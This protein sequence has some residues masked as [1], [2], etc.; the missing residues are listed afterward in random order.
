MCGPA[1]QGSN[2]GVICP[3]DEEK[4][5]GPHAEGPGCYCAGVNPG[6]G[7]LPTQESPSCRD[8]PVHRVSLATGSSQTEYRVQSHAA[9]VNGMA[10][11]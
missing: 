10:H 2:W 4:A 8:S 6:G 3:W 5:A 11:E 7:Q 1:S 9:S